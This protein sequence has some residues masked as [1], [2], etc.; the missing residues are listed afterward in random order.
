MREQ[1]AALDQILAGCPLHFTYEDIQIFFLF[2]SRA[3]SVTKPG[4]T[5]L[6]D[7]LDVV[8]GIIYRILQTWLES[9]IAN[10]DQA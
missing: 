4:E 8:I 1:L 7:S 6:V 10:T 5:D 3:Q 2:L 9:K